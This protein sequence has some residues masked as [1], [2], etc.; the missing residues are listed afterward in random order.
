M[1]IWQLALGNIWTSKI[2]FDVE[3]N[4]NT[5]S[6]HLFHNYFPVLNPFFFFH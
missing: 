2:D 4:Q 3:K 1:R 5:K 6:K